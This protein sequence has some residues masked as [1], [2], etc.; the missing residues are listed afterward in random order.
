MTFTQERQKKILIALTA[1][2]AL[3]ITYR[4]LTAEK[5]KTAPL[6]YK[7][8]AVASSPVRQGVLSQA[9][10]AD[11]LN[12]FLERRAEKFPGVARDIFRMENPAPRRKP[13]AS[14]PAPPV[15]VK[16]PEEIAAEA[17][18][19]AAEAARADL[20]K[21]RFLGYLTSKDNTVFLSK[22][23]EL[24]IVKSGDQV[25]RNYKVIETGKDH[26]V[27]LDTITRVEVRIYLSGAAP[28]YQQPQ[29]QQAPPLSPQQVQPQPQQSPQPV[30]Q[31]QQQRPPIYRK[32]PASG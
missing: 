17:A 2:L 6:T 30:P 5:P 13:A 27:L 28:S 25:L 4:I 3:L 21:F 29:P 8:G 12:V 20:S 15:H 23:G 31:P 18:L 1:V 24:F 11:P 9:G 19:S 16:T 26:V 32:R 14:Q 7:R 10:G 22:D